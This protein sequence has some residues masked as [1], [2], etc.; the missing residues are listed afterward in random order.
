M[1]LQGVLLGFILTAVAIY[2][3]RH[4]LIPDSFNLALAVVG[5]AFLYQAGYDSSISAVLASVMG[6]LALLI[7]RF[8]YKKWRGVDGLGL[9]DVKFMFAAGLWL[10]PQLLPWLLLFASLSGIAIALLF[11]GKDMQARLPFGPHL[12]LGTL[13]CWLLKANNVL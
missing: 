11:H 13:A 12:A 8:V 7:A 6:G 3:A 1:I 5:A 10:T 2:D 9:G 4:M